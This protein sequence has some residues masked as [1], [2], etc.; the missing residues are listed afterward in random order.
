MAASGSTRQRWDVGAMRFMNPSGGGEA[1]LYELFTAEMSLS[2][3]SL[4]SPNSIV[5]FGSR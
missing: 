2:T 3:D 5:V 4:A 1:T